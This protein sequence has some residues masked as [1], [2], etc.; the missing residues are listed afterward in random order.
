MEL[1]GK[2]EERGRGRRERRHGRGSQPKTK[3]LD[4]QGGSAERGRRSAEAAIIS[5]HHYLY[6][7]EIYANGI[8]GKKC[9]TKRV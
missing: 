5:H 6:G 8:S 2:G 1:G 3:A 9:W 7:L 4:P